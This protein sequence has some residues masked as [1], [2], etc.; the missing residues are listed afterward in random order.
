MTD[1]VL[2][3]DGNNLEVYASVGDG[4]IQVKS[5]KPDPNNK[6]DWEDE[7]ILALLNDG[8]KYRLLKR[9]QKM[10]EEPE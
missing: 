7:E 1:K 6:V 2:F 5:L 9:A 3:N 4:K 8:M 10:Q